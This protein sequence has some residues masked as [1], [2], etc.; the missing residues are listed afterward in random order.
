MSLPEPVVKLLKTKRYLHLATCV[1]GKPHVCLMNYTYLSEEGK[2]YIVLS[3]P[4]RS[5]KFTNMVQNPNVSL[6][7][8]DWVNLAPQPENGRRNLLYELLANINKAEISSVSVMLDGTAEVI[9][10]DCARHRYL[11]QLHLNNGFIDE[12]QAQNYITK[13]DNAL[14]LISVE[15]CKVTDANDNVELY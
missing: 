9:S 11:K 12:V 2:N 7:V 4:K 1:D 14:V 13:T 6:L 10:D 15:S 8:H 5:T 3:T